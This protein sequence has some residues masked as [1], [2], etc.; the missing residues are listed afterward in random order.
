MT[1]ITLKN[2]STNPIYKELTP[3]NFPAGSWV[4][5]L[6]STSIFY[7]VSWV[8]SKTLRTINV[9]QDGYISGEREY[10]APLGSEYREIESVEISYKLK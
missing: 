3:E 10:A 2:L 8:G 7:I 4:K 5:R 9:H 1:T 6:D